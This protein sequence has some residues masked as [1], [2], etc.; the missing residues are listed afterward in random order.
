M[1]EVAGSVVGQLN[2]IDGAVTDVRRSLSEGSGREVPRIPAMVLIEAVLNAVSHRSYCS[3]EPI[4][5]DVS[6]DS[7]RVSSPGGAVRFGLGSDNR[8]RN[9]RLNLVLTEM[10]FKSLAVHGS[11]GMAKAYKQS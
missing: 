7:V 9:P 2:D 11:V 1:R 6:L 3:R 10:G 5:V 4:V 8:T